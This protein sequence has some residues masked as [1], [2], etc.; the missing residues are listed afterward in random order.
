M[1]FESSCIPHQDFAAPNG[2]I[3]TKPGTIE[4]DT[5]RTIVPAI[6]SDHSGE[7]SMMMLDSKS[8]QTFLADRPFCRLVLRME[9]VGKNLGLDFQNRASMLD[10]ILKE[11]QGC[12]VIEVSDVLAHENSIPS[13]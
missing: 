4:D 7:M 6:L 8:M 10:A 5:N 9:I 3:Q 12:R 13:A 11:L 1:A 2:P